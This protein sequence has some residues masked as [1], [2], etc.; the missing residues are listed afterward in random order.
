[1]PIHPLRLLPIHPLYIEDCDLT[2]HSPRFPL[3]GF[4]T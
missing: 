4:W 2:M 1:M 3:F